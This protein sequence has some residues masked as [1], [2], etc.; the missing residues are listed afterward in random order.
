MI[1]AGSVWAGYE[2]GVISEGESELFV[3]LEGN[4]HLI[5]DGGEIYSLSV[6]DDGFIEVKD[7][8]T[9][10]SIW[11][12]PDGPEDFGGL[13]YAHLYD[14]SSLVQTGGT[15]GK[16][17]LYDN[18]TMELDEGFLVEIALNDN[19]TVDL[20]GGWIY[21]IVSEQSPAVKSIRM[22]CRDD[23]NWI[24]HTYPDEISGIAGH[25]YDGTAFEISFLDIRRGEHFNDTWMNVEII[26]PE[27][28]SLILLGL[29]GLLIRRKC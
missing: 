1:S 26:T 10:F 22:Y 25:W 6:K 7:T 11:W 15:S 18:S 27:P 17:L 19:A 29:G 24:Y 20:K 4:S 9:L 13:C 3:S 8:T 14:N 28:T 23:W 16:Y 12:I 21:S 2:D 5:I